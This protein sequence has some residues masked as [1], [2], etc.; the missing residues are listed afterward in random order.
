MYTKH[1]A[2][3]A[4]VRADSVGDFTGSFAEGP[5]DTLYLEF[6]AIRFARVNGCLPPD[7][8]NDFHGLVQG[9]AKNVDIDFTPHQ[10]SDFD[11]TVRYLPGG[12]VMRRVIVESGL[13]TVSGDLGLP[14][15]DPFAQL[16]LEGYTTVVKGLQL[17]KQ[18]CQGTRRTVPYSFLAEV[19]QAP[20]RRS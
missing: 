11:K 9:H 6:E 4:S 16:V 15:Y 17:N 19:F 20:V 13:L 12:K 3:M 1:Y 5:G 7:D 14:E 18:N 8:P 2:V 10:D